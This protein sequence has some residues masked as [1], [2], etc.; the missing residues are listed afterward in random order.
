MRDADVE[1]VKLPIYL[2]ELSQ[3]LDFSTSDLEDNRAG[4]LSAAQLSTQ[5]RVLARSAT[6]AAVFLLLAGACVA[7]ALAVGVTTG[8]GILILVLA[9]PCLAFVGLWARYAIPRW[10]D[11]NA[12]LV[13]TVEGFIQGG[14]RETTV[15]VSSGTMPI[16]SYYWTVDGGQRFWVRGKAY[17]VLMPAR[18]RLYFLPS[19]RRVVAAEPV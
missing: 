4:R 3:A 16:W 18:H 10:R 6:L 11:V 5:L 7:G 1:Y 8:L 14:E 19:S 13:S 17:A 2:E 15:R 9:L 12:G